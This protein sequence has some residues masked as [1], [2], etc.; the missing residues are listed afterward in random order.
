M[1]KFLA[2]LKILIEEDLEKH[3]NRPV[4]NKY[5]WTCLVA[6]FLLIQFFIGPFTVCIW[7]GAWRLYDELFLW[8]FTSKLETWNIGIVCMALGTSISCFVA[9]YYREIDALAKKTGSTRYFLVSRVY[10]ILK[11]LTA[12]LYW[13]GL[14]INR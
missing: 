9:L 2:D 4:K 13:K 1:A 14:L 11:F 5:L 12:L 7:R 3:M 8:I 10:S 6:D